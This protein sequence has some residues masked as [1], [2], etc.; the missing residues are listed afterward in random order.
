MPNVIDDSEERRTLLLRINAYEMSGG[1]YRLPQDMLTL[2]RAPIETL[3]RVSVMCDAYER[4][5]REERELRRMHREIG[6]PNLL[7]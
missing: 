3:R 1:R 7:N 4:V 5:E 2:L 6:F